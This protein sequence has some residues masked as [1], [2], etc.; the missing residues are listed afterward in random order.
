VSISV[1]ITN[2]AGDAV[3]VSDAEEDRILICRDLES[4]WTLCPLNSLAHDPSRLLLI[5]RRFTYVTKLCGYEIPAGICSCLKD[6]CVCQGSHLTDQDTPDGLLILNAKRREPWDHTHQEVVRYPTYTETF[7]HGHKPLDPL[8]LRTLTE[9]WDAIH[10]GR[11]A[12]RSGPIGH[13]KALNEIRSFVANVKGA[14]V[15][16]DHPAWDAERLA[17]GQLVLFTRGAAASASAAVDFIYRLPNLDVPLRVEDVGDTELVISCGDQ[18]LV[19]VEQYLRA[20]QDRPLRLTLDKQE[21]DRGIKRE[22]DTL[23][24]AETAHRLRALIGD[25]TLATRTPARAPAAFFHPRLDPGQRAVVT[26]A[27]AADELLAVQGPPGT[28]KTTTITEIIRQHL[29]RDP[30]AQ[31][32]LAAQTHVAVD[33]VLL[34]LTEAEPDLPVARV[35][36]KHT[37]DKVNQTIRERYWTHST[38]PWYPPTMRRADS[39][40]RLTDSQI[41]AYDKQ[42]DDVTTRVLEIQEDYLAS[43]GPQRTPAERLARARV[44]GGTCAGVQSNSEVRAMTFALAILEEAGKA[45]PP[46]ALMVAL[47]S[48]KTIYVGDTRQLP[49]NLWKPMETVVRDPA[50]LTTENPHLQDRARQMREAIGKL[51]STPDERVAAD[52]QTLLAH[53][54]LAL[55]GTAHEVTLNT[56]YRMLPEIG[57]LVGQ[58]F[59]GDI[60]GLRHAREKP[61]DP[62]VPA[63]AGDVRVKLIDIPGQ[64][65]LQGTSKHRSAEVRQIAGELRSLNDHAAQVRA[66]GIPINGPQRLGVTVLT[67]YSAQAKALARAFRQHRTQFPA[68]NLRIG[69]VDSFQGNEDQVVILSIAATTVAGFLKTPNRINVAVSRAQD[70]LIV[71]TSLPAAKKGNI[72][73]PLQRVVQYIDDRVK[74]GDPAFQIVRPARPKPRPSHGRH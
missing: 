66:G 55:R 39:F 16:L 26:A 30:H 21:A 28:G 15:P 25:P 64:E 74:A 58:V 3:R 63:F 20:E 44:I 36:S 67:P 60:G 51:G 18:D 43:I 47:R 42:L 37:I 17:E 46:E 32:L 59:Y 19:G 56:Q 4:G 61:I 73:K 38:E 24:A 50:Q 54:T 12:A 41:L 68:L 10:R 65:E 35:A 7:E 62:R 5:G 72:G 31:I 22:A 6:P 71:T 9:R 49:P 23:R 53:F 11:A 27:L 8:T 40:R 69:I 14:V 1:A 2:T 45:T 70:L 48:H 29:A 13:W 52:E 57:Q 34:R 33:N